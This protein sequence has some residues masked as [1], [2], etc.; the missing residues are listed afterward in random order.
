MAVTVVDHGEAVQVDLAQRDGRVR[1][2][3]LQNGLEADPEVLLV[4]QTGQQVVQ[5]LVA[6]P[7]LQQVHVT[8]VLDHRDVLGAVTL[9]V[10][11][12]R[13]RERCP[14][15]LLRGGA[16]PDSGP[17]PRPLPVDELLIR[18]GQ[19]LRVVRVEEFADRSAGEF[20]RRV[21]ED[22]GQGGIG[23]RDGT[24]RPADRDTQRGGVEHRPETGPRSPAGPVRPRGWP[25]AAHV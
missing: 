24:V 6:Q 22:L 13:H 16:E 15:G 4:G 8:D 25:A 12:H 14:G 23:V 9:R 20:G 2:G 19:P 3:S 11:Q 7:L 18:D 1:L 21:A 17:E 5:R 10:E